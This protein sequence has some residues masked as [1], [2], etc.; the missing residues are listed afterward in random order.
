MPRR[1]IKL[2]PDVTNAEKLSLNMLASINPGVRVTVSLSRVEA[3]PKKIRDISS[4]PL[5]SIADIDSSISGSYMRTTPACLHLEGND[6][7]AFGAILDLL[8][9]L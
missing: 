5:P 7:V 4:T 9:K 6:V 1:G 8:G 3:G 2:E